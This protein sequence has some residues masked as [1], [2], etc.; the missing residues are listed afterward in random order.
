M[1]VESTAR[2]ELNRRIRDAQSQRARIPAELQ[3]LSRRRREALA[4]DRDDEAEKCA[5]QSDDLRK[6]DAQLEEKL[7][8]LESGWSAIEVQEAAA[9]IPD[10]T[11]EL[12]AAM[13]AYEKRDAAAVGKFLAVLDELAETRGQAFELSQ[14]L[15]QLRILYRTA[16]LQEPDVLK[17]EIPRF[18]GGAVWNLSNRIHE[19]CF[20]DGNG[21][22]L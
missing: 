19:I 11:M 4:A 12:E 15:T 16:G 17:R 1:V 14:R 2:Q 21:G 9:R 7:Q 5:A 10:E 3:E 6:L 22:R 13:K 8:I 18:D 20:S